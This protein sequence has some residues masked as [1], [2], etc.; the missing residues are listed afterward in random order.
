MLTISKRRNIVVLGLLSLGFLA[1]YLVSQ[2]AYITDILFFVGVFIHSS[3]IWG[4]SR[5]LIYMITAMLLGYTAEFIGINTGLVFGLY[6]Y[7]PVNPGLIFGVPYFIPVEYAYLLYAGNMLVIAIS[8][9]FLLKKNIWM[10]ATLSGVI[11]TLKDLC[12]DPIKS[13]V[14]HIWIWDTAGPYFGEPIHNF[15]GWFFVFAILT[16]A[17]TGLA[18]HRGNMSQ[19]VKLDKQA[20]YF[21]LLMLSALV[22]F[23]LSLALSVPA[24][25]R[26]LGDVS[27]F[28]ILIGVLPYMLL[29]WFNLKNR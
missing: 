28:I 11:L 13:T 9:T 20:F 6:H 3:A 12:T 18:W 7:N 21:P 26:G 22:I 17:A 10:L 16:L 15:V 29:G 24:S 25:Y 8:D 19:T 23:A 2:Y 14:E 27:A 5:T 1:H 4:R